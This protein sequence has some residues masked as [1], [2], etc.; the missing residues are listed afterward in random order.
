MQI[1][2]TICLLLLVA[3]VALVSACSPEVGSDEWCN[4]MKEKPKKDW[5]ASE[6]ANYT[7]YCIFK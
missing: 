2:K 4:N 6:A 5:T 7:K 3:F 1:Q